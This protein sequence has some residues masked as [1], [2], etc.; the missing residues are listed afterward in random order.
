MRLTTLFRGTEEKN[1]GPLVLGKPSAMPVAEVLISKLA[2]CGIPA[3]AS[4]PVPEI[5]KVVVASTIKFQAAS[6]S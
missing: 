6:L 3:A 4:S 2:V 5:F 1:P